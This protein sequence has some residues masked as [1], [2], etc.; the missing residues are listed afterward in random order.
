MQSYNTYITPSTAY[1]GVLA[2]VLDYPDYISAPRGQKT[3][4]KV[5]YMFRVLQPSSLPIVTHSEARNKIIAQYTVKECDLYQTGLKT[6][7]DYAKIS[8]FWEKLANPDGT[9]N[10]AY[11]YL[12]FH[13]KSCGNLEFERERTGSAELRTPWE[14]ARHSLIADKDTRQA[15]MPFNLPEHLWAGNRDV[16]CTLHAT[17]MIRNDRLNLTVNMRANDLYRG[18]VYDFS[19]FMSLMDKMLDEL[20][21]H[22]P[23]LKK[24][25]YT[26][27]ADSFHIYERDLDDVYAMLGRVRTVQK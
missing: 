13:Q 14:W 9:I 3:F 8:K 25:H 2:D 10:S 5:N 1:Q 16:T 22:Y 27:K 4:E 24:G 11:G 18:L 7:A 17:F 23:A 21:P 6:A 15:I 20:L 19:W 26:H 12:I